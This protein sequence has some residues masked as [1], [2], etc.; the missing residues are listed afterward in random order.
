[1]EAALKEAELLSPT[2][3]DADTAAMRDNPS[4]WFPVPRPE[5]AFLC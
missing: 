3:L 1:M 2:L 4:S 5:A